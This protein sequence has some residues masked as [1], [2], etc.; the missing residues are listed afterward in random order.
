[1]IDITPIMEAIITLV[2]LCITT[3]LIPY[4]K[5]KTTSA[6][7]EQIQ[8]WVNIAVMAAEQLIQGSGMGAEKKEYVIKWLNKHNITFDAEKLDAMIEAAVYKLTNS[9][10]SIEIPVE[11][12]NQIEPETLV[13]AKAI[14][15]ENMATAK[16]TTKTKSTKTKTNTGTSE[17]TSEANTEENK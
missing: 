8:A 11:I 3:F 7:Q 10:T 12:S 14:L 2:F 5:S 17:N 13:A 1:M 6:Q 9:P 15:D 16:K 4:I